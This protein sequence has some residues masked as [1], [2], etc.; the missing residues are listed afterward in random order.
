M[1]KTADQ[2]YPLEPRL[3]G[4]EGDPVPAGK[5]SVVWRGQCPLPDLQIVGL[6]SSL[7]LQEALKHIGHSVPIPSPKPVRSRSGTVDGTVPVCGAKP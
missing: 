3:S 5:E 7:R 2:L 6:A 1:W 4:K